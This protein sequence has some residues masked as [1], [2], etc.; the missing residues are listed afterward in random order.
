MSPSSTF[1]PAQGV[2]RSSIWA[3]HPIVKVILPL[4]LALLVFLGHSHSPVSQS[5]D[6]GWAIPLSLSILREHDLDL[7]E[8]ASQ[9]AP[10]DSRVDRIDGHYFSYFPYGTSLLSLP[11]VWLAMQFDPQLADPSQV[12]FPEME[13]IIASAIIAITSL[14]MYAVAR[15]R[16]LSVITAFATTILFAFGTSVWSTASR[17]L[18]QHGPSILMLSLGLYLLGEAEKRPQRIQYVALPL[19]FAYIIR[20]TNSIALLVVS[21]YVFLCYRA[22]FWRY[23]LWGGAVAMLFV[24]INFSTFGALLPRYFLPERVGDTALFWTALA[25]NLISPARGLFVFTPITLL[26]GV[27]VVQRIRELTKIEKISVAIILLHWLLIS[28]FPHWWGGWS[29]GPRFFTDMMPFFWVLLFPLVLNLG[30]VKWSASLPL[31]FLP[32]A[33]IGVFIHLQGAT[34]TETYAPW[35][36]LPVNVEK[37]HARLWNWKDP[38][39]L[40]GATGLDWLIAPDIRVIPSTK[41]AIHDIDN[42]APEWISF[43]VVN[44]TNRPLHWLA[45]ASTGLQIVSFDMPDGISGTLV[46]EAPFSTLRPIEN[47]F[48]VNITGTNESGR[49]QTVKTSF[50]IYLDDLK[51]LFLPLIH[52]P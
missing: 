44:Y 9:I 34:V 18:W 42:P 15:Q 48:S 2:G 32:L 7:D 3:E 36:A 25:G 37:D 33:A 11:F 16:R 22:Y 47:N 27:G 6:S 12:A 45:A 39:F 28:T 41:T 14:V 13:V 30:N 17:A 50:T 21:L 23:L 26:I 5:G 20:P 19:A 1:Q 35:S 8:Y 49:Q 31:V 43:Q 4:L 46:V 29:Y 38:Q 40:R 51:Q 10:S 24:A 52:A